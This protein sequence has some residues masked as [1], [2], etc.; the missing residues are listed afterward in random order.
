MAEFAAVSIV[1]MCNTNKRS[2]VYCWLLPLSAPSL[3][4]VIKMLVKI[5]Y[6]F[7]FAMRFP[8]KSIQTIWFSELTKTLVRPC[9]VKSGTLFEA[10][11]TH[12]SCTVT[13]IIIIYNS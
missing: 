1:H 10:M 13:I 8:F 7:D 9:H 4:T 12:A 3:F 11:H 6:R 5:Y 2:N